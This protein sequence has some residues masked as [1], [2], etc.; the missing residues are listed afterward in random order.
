MMKKILIFI[1]ALFLSQ[2]SL[3]ATCRALI[4]GI[5]KY[6][7]MKTGWHPIHGD[8]DVELLVPLLKKQGFDDIVSLVNEKATKSEIV[9]QLIALSQRCKAGDKVYFHFSGHGQ[10]I[11]DD[12]GD[13]KG[14]KKFDESI[15]PYDACRD[16]RKMNGTYI[17][18]FHL[19]DDELTPLLDAIKKKLGSGG[20]LFVAVD[21][22][23]SRGIQKDEMTD[24]DPVLLRYARGTDHAFVPSGRKSFVSGLPKPKEF[25][26]GAKLVVVTA[27]R[28]NERNFE[29]KAP[30]NKM[31]GSLSYYIS[32]LLKDNIDFDRWATSFQ[33]KRYTGK[34][35]FQS[36]QH[37]SIEIHE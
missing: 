23:Y 33:E 20:I 28:E 26:P 21:A 24:F 17:G 10:P 37:P 7:R 32:T 3:H 4:V 11:R 15:I 1:L 5:G 2:V 13:E 31:Y 34:R 6:D 14:T 25:S 9:K 18:Q 27:C 12:N 36:I 30:G 22:C 8:N 19:I 29:Y 16:S 35:I